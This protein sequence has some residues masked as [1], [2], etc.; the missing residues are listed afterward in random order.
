M[1]KATGW[2]P[3][4]HHV[5]PPQPL[6]FHSSLLFTRIRILPQYSRNS[7]LARLREADLIYS[8]YPSLVLISVPIERNLLVP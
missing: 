7:G 4:G 6:L 3:S 1:N 5:R 8:I 2:R